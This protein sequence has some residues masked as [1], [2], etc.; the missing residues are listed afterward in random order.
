MARPSLL[1][2]LLAILAL[3]AA[4][5]GVHAAERPERPPL[6]SRAE[7]QA[8]LNQ[9]PKAAADPRPLHVLLVA[10]PK[11]HGPGEHD[12]PARLRSWEPLVAKAPNVTVSTAWK[13]P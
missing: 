3:A 9:A 4:A 2:L 1:G 7:V 11:D 12:Y 13:W 6:R 5:A 10:G 8:V